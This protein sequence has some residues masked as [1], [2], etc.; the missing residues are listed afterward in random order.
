MVEDLRIALSVRLSIYIP[1]CFN[2]G[3]NSCTA[4][5]LTQTC[6]AMPY[7]SLV[8]TYVRKISWRNVNHFSFCCSLTFCSLSKNEIED[9]G[10]CALAGALQV[11]QSLQ[12]L[13]WVQPFM[14]YSTETVVP[15]PGLCVLESVWSSDRHSLINVLPTTPSHHLL[16]STFFTLFLFCCSLTFCSLSENKITD[17]GICELAR[18]LQVNQ[19][20]HGVKW[21]CQLCPVC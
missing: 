12:Q 17:K 21:V 8:A 3:Y 20:L 13:E 14:S 11:N 5:S 9:K 10:V 19:S 6:P 4:H 16:S 2:Q 1:Y 15:F 7:I 18:A